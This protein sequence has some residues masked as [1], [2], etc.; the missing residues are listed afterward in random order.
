[1]GD[2]GFGKFLCW[3]SV[4]LALVTLTALVSVLYPQSHGECTAC[5]PCPPCTSWCQAPHAFPV[6]RLQM[7]AGHCNGQTRLLGCMNPRGQ[8]SQELPVPRLL[9]HSSFELYLKQ[10]PKWQGSQQEST[11]SSCSGPGFCEVLGSKR[12][13]AH[14]E[15][16][17]C[18]S[19]APAPMCEPFPAVS[20]L[21]PCCFILIL[22]HPILLPLG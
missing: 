17:S 7:T 15:Q 13:G 9:L 21:P 5:H 4:F 19:C 16:G 11:G 3:F 12:A 2:A 18:S 6:A 14:G 22:V 8:T 10:K 20:T 1:M